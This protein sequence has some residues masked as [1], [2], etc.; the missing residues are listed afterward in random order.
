MGYMDNFKTSLNQVFRLSPNEEIEDEE[1]LDDQTEPLRDADVT[2]DI[3]IDKDDQKHK[4]LSRGQ[5]GRY[6]DKSSAFNSDGNSIISADTRIVGKIISN[7]NLLIGGDVEGDIVAK[8][9]VRVKGK[10]KGSISANRVELSECSVLGNI[11]AEASLMIDAG[12]EVIGDIESGDTSIDG[13]IKGNVL[14]TADVLCKKNSFILGNVAS[15]SISIEKGS[16]V[17][18]EIQ[19]KCT[20]NADELFSKYFNSGK[21]G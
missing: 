17:C 5:T 16:V 10:V 6:E 4:Y 1:M 21:Q 13:K 2:E 15:D 19:I 8:G 12:S 9:D 20:E 7:G 18:G 14:S 11:R 3:S